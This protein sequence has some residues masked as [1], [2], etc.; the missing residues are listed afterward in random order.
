MMMM[1]MRNMLP[2]RRKEFSENGLKGKRKGCGR[3]LGDSLMPI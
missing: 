1:Q 3:E 2:G